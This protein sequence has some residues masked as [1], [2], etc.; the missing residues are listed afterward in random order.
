MSMNNLF[1]PKLLISGEVSSFPVKLV[2]VD[3]GLMGRSTCTKI[4]AD[5]CAVLDSV[6]SNIQKYFSIIPEYPNCQRP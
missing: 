4:S 2:E 6:A 1:L 5:Q 3:K